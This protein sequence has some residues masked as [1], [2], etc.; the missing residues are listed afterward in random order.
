[1]LYNNTK[2]NTELIV[3][4]DLF[5]NLSKLSRFQGGT[6]SDYEKKKAGYK[7][8]EYIEKKHDYEGYYKDKQQKRQKKS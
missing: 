2:H 7:N 3:A 8:H 4:Q 5:G 6:Q 1:M